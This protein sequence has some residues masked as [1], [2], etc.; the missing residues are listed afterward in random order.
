VLLKAGLGVLQ[1]KRSKAQGLRALFGRNKEFI[2]FLMLY[3][4]TQ[5][6]LSHSFFCH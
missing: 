1:P 2:E 3:E 6:T 5:S 4:A